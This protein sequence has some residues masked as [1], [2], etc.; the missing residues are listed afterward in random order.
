MTFTIIPSFNSEWRYVLCVYKLNASK[1]QPLTIFLTK[2]LIPISVHFPYESPESF[3]SIL[4]NPIPIIA[5]MIAFT[6]NNIIPF[7][8]SRHIFFLWQQFNSQIRNYVGIENLPQPYSAL[9]FTTHITNYM[10]YTQM[11]YS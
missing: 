2:I 5:L 9:T 4:I 7:Q 10:F 8:F 6:S 1:N 11:S 3:A